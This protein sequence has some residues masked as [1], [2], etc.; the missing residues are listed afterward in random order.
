VN[1]V[2]PPTHQVCT[3]HELPIPSIPLPSAPLAQPTAPLT[4]QDGAGAREGKGEERGEGQPLA[5]PTS[6]SCSLPRG[7]LS[8]QC[9]TA[10]GCLCPTSPQ[11]ASAG[12]A[13][14]SWTWGN[15]RVTPGH[16]A[17]YGCAARSPNPSL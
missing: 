15:L 10:A 6:W 12:A 3:T 13:P 16:R 8:S 17:P 9:G 2:T 11:R 1:G 5:A 4:V 14:Q 7:R